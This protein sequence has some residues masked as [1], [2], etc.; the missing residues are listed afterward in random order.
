MKNDLRIDFTKNEIIMSRSFEK[1]ASIAGSEEYRRLQL[2]R[3]DYPNFSVVRRSIKK[4]PTKVTYAGLTYAYIEAYIAG[5][6]QDG[7]IKKVYDELR[8]IGAC[9]KVSYPTIKKWFLETYPEIVE[10]GI[11]G[12]A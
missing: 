12:A 4:S 6:D 8:L 9:H 3:Q 1:C 7:T 10:F 5:H 11:D 2:V